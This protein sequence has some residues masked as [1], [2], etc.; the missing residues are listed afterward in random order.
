MQPSGQ[1][2]PPPRRGSAGHWE[3]HG[4]GRGAQTRPQ[5]SPGRRHQHTGLWERVGP[6]EPSS[7]P[8]PWGTAPTSPE[9][10]SLPAC[11][12]PHPRGGHQPVRCPSPPAQTDRA[13][14]HFRLIW[15]QWGGPGPGSSEQGGG[16]AH[17]TWPAWRPRWGSGPLGVPTAS[18]SG[19]LQETSLGHGLGTGSQE[20]EVRG[21]AGGRSGKQGWVGEG[22]P[23]PAMESELAGMCS[24]QHCS[25]AWVWV[26]GRCPPPAT[27]RHPPK[28]CS[29]TFL[30]PAFC[31]SRYS[32]AKCA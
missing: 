4:M 13:A 18:S 2:S 21:R 6:E 12:S 25:Q 19:L 26:R 22:S 23:A 3:S 31:V 28:S 11:G 15:G 5:D 1:Q 29:Q 16:S 30:T 14:W 9:E 20:G 32:K 24:E 10:P 17:P 27:H 8:C 7:D